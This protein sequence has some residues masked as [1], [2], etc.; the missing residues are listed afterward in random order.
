MKKKERKGTEV[1]KEEKKDDKLI[2]KKK[3]MKWS[4]DRLNE[5]RRKD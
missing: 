2:K 5:R 1:E 4:E 3:E